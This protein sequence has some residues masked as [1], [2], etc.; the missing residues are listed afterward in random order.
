MVE[1]LIMKVFKSLSILGIVISVVK[2]QRHKIH[3]GLNL[4]AKHYRSRMKIECI[5][6]FFFIFSRTETKWTRLKQI[7]FYMLCHENEN[8][9]ERHVRGPDKSPAHPTIQKS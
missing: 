7:T 9:T 5:Y 8:Q 2:S 6:T 4:E 3:S 1:K